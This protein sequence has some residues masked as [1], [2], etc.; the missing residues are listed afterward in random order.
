MFKLFQSLEQWNSGTHWQTQ[1]QRDNRARLWLGV[2]WV[3]R[4]TRRR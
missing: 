2:G 1:W 3:T 4:L